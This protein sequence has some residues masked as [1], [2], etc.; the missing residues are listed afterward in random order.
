MTGSAVLV[1]SRAARVAAFLIAVVAAL[2]WS[3][4]VAHAQQ[5]EEDQYGG[6]VAPSGPLAGA[7][8]Q[9]ANDA[10]P[11]G[12]VGSGDV[13]VIAGDFNVADGASIT[14]QDSDAT[15][16]TLIDGQNANITEGSVIIEVT[17]FPIINAPG[18]NGV[19]NTEGL[20]VVASTGISLEEGAAA[21]GEATAGDGAETGDGV[22]ASILPDTGG[23]ATVALLAGGFLAAGGGLLVLRRQVGN[24]GQ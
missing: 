2:V 24:R 13:L 14:L 18:E 8:V 19:L 9:V 12:V 15:Q 21:G 20:T 7:S 22:A 5:A 3:G 6:A 16:G 4:N 11:V 1:R 10:D 17:D 23:I